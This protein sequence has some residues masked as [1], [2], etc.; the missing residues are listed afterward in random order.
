M[1]EPYAKRL[2]SATPLASAAYALGGTIAD[3]DQDRARMTELRASVDVIA[4]R[5]GSED[6]FDAPHLADRLAATTLCDRRKVLTLDEEQAARIAD[7]C[8]ACVEA[9]RDRATSREAAPATT[10]A[11]SAHQP[12]PIRPAITNP[13]VHRFHSLEEANDAPEYRDDIHDGDLLVIARE[14]VVALLNRTW[15]AALTADRLGLHKLAKP[16]YEI[17]DGRYAASVRLAMELGASLGVE[18]N[19]PAPA[20]GVHEGQPGRV[21]GRRHP[22]RRRRD[23]HQHAHLGRDRRR[24]RVAR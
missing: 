17:E 11:G 21:R 8:P 24:L 3:A 22:H 19:P 5:T 4:V 1:T 18:L 9:A 13:A 12:E 10:E 6:D 15:P 16:A 14:G 7:F 20:A 2:A 23:A